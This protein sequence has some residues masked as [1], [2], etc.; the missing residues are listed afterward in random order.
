MGTSVLVLAV[1]GSSV[2]RIVGLDGIRHDG[3]CGG[4]AFFSAAGAAIWL[5]P[6]AI[7][8]ATRHGDDFPPTCREGFESAGFDVA[9]VQVASGRSSHGFDARYDAEQI[10]TLTVEGETRNERNDVAAAWPFGTP[11]PE[12]DPI[13]DMERLAGWPDL[14][15]A[16][17]API[18][19]HAT[20]ENLEH[21]R[22]RTRWRQIDP[23]EESVAWSVDDRSR[24]LA[25]VDGYLPSQHEVGFAR[26]GSWLELCRDVAARGPSVV[27]IR[28]GREG[29]FVFDRRSD[30]GA[31]IP[32]V[33]VAPVDPTG[34]GD[35]YCGGF[36]AGMVLS[37]DAMVAALLATVAA[38]AAVESV[39]PVPAT[40]DLEIQRERLRWLS[41][42]T[43]QPIPVGIGG[44]S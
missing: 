34:A 29:S 14:Q 23:G 38:A 2:D 7:A 13:V 25:D 5:D 17:V 3:V 37:G 33:P 1:G 12:L 21:L 24:I 15:G 41:A 28:L 32:P 8:I 42:R 26:T 36:L 18:G 19:L 30:R 43:G 6:N 20:F 11:T 16:H 31:L 27:A 44:T 22:S 4:N 9:E 10:R 39:G 35:A 40:A